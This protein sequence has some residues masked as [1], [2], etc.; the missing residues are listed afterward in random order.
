MLQY[1]FLSKSSDV[2][3]IHYKK[4]ITEKKE[5]VT[6]LRGLVEQTVAQLLR[7]F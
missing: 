2:L 3:N 4:V 6:A 7:F 5:H 1:P